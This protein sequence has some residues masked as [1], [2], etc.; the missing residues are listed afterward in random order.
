MTGEWRAF[1]GI[2]PSKTCM[3]NL[4]FCASMIIALTSS[5]QAYTIPMAWQ[6]DSLGGSWDQHAVLLLPVK[7]E[8][9]ARTFY[10]QFDLGSP[11]SLFY[12]EQLDKIKVILPA[13]DTIPAINIR[14]GNMNRRVRSVP[15]RSFPQ[16]GGDR[17]G[18][19]VIGTLGAD[20]LDQ[21]VVIFDYP[22]RR[23]T[24]T[25]VLPASLPAPKHPFYFA[26]GRIFF[27]AIIRQQQTLLYFDTGSSAFQLL[28]DSASWQQMADPTAHPLSYPVNSW[29]RTLT[30]HT[31]KTSDSI[32]I[33]SLSIPVFRVTYIEGA[34]TNQVS[35]MKKMGIGGMTGNTLFLDHL[36]ML[37]MKQ[38]LFLLTKP[39]TK[40]GL[41]RRH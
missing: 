28:T 6:G 24:I 12:K 20:I 25:N 38:K 37:D 7:L 40:G 22:H 13:G 33:A 36:L 32:G 39:S 3:K 5:G 35:M 29:G 17:K 23:L 14:I 34:D 31:T 26:G 1:P 4:L 8:G 41:L 30:A 10:M 9:S 19:P 2:L 27:P 11:Y 21:R 15:V 16:K 18:L